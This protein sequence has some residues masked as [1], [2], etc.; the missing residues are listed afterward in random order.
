MLFG[1]VTILAT[2][3]QRQDPLVDD[4]PIRF[5]L[6][7][8]SQSVSGTTKAS[9]VSRVIMSSNS[10]ASLTCEVSEQG[11]QLTTRSD[12]ITTQT[13]TQL[14]ICAQRSGGSTYFHDVCFSKQSDG[15]FQSN[16][17]YFWPN[18]E[19]LDLYCYYPQSKEFYDAGISLSASGEA[20]TFHYNVPGN[21]YPQVDLSVAYVKASPSNNKITLKHAL[22]RILFKVGENLPVGT[23]I[24]SIEVRGFKNNGTIYMNDI[25]SG[26]TL[27]SSTGSFS[28][29]PSVP[30]WYISQKSKS[31]A[32]LSPSE[33]STVTG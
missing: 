30:F 29:V 2:A 3:C 31:E 12:I 32:V 24:S 7:E 5:I 13:I 6:D 16:P 11:Q 20:M 1:C 18:D 22:T 10:N 26:W 19:L 4:N 17:P 28:D 14:G 8:A 21:V 15:F 27:E 9:D 33:L 23:Q 25:D